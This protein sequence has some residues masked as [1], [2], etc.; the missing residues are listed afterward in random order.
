MDAGRAGGANEHTTTRFLIIPT[1]QNHAAAADEPICFSAACNIPRTLLI[2]RARE[3]QL[4]S[5]G[6]NAIG[7]HTRTD[8]RVDLP[9]AGARHTTRPFACLTRLGSARLGWLLL[10]APVARCCSDTVLGASQ[11]VSYRTSNHAEITPR[12][13]ASRKHTLNH[14][15]RR[16]DE[17]Q[18]GYNKQHD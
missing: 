9:I 2:L 13:Q 15:S 12:E 1:F 5:S 7:Q 14:D 10:V 4:A 11:H 18:P 6:R 16:P 8:I 17:I 3:Q